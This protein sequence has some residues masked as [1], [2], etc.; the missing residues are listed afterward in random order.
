MNDLMMQKLID[1]LNNIAKA[2]EHVSSSIDELSS[3]F[4]NKD[5]VDTK[6]IADA[7]DGLA[8]TIKHKE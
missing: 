5:D 1:A 2:T 8:N 6:T 7:I 3:T 4:Y